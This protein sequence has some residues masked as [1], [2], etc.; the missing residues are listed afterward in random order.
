MMLDFDVA[1]V[2]VFVVAMCAIVDEQIE[3]SAVTPAIFADLVRTIA[4]ATTEQQRAYFQLLA[5]TA[6]DEQWSISLRVV[7]KIASS[8]LFG[9]FGEIVRRCDFLRRSPGWL[10]RTRLQLG[11]ARAQVAH[12]DRLAAGGRLS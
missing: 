12:E 8:P 9:G 1:D 2:R 5:A 6:T 10:E 3:P 7:L 4:T 11:S